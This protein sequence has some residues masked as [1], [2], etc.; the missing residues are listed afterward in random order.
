MD[1]PAE[2]LGRI[3]RGSLRSTIIFLKTPNTRPEGAE[4]ISLGHSD[5]A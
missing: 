3:L 4:Q 1:H 2:S 5:A